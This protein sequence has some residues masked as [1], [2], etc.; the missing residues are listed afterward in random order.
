MV[1]NV[2]MNVMV[3]VLEVTILKTMPMIQIL[4][5]TM[6]AIEMLPNVIKWTDRKQ[7]NILK[8]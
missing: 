4:K 2:I 3:A 6:N 8:V 5:K 1:T 7:H